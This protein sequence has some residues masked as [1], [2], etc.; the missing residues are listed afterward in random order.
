MRLAWWQSHQ[1]GG[2]SFRRRR[3]GA[4]SLPIAWAVVMAGLYPRMVAQAVGRSM[5]FALSIQRRMAPTL[6]LA[7]RPLRNGAF[8]QRYDA[9]A[10]SGDPRRQTLSDPR[11]DRIRLEYAV[12][13]P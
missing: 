6:G 4:S 8:W 7:E 2:P 5:T 11:T 1:E 9:R 10:L 13:A 3:S 12:G